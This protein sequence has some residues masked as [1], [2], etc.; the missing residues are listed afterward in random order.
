MIPE[1]VARGVAQFS[2]G[3]EEKGIETS[4]LAAIVSSEASS[5]LA[6][7]KKGLRPYEYARV[8]LT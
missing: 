1:I 3:P 4:R 2:T 8:P 6:L 7:K 5:A